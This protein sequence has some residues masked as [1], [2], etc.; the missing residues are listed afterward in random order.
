MFSIWWGLGVVLVISL[1]WL[2]V[3]IL[4]LAVG[5]RM[6]VRHPCRSSASRNCPLH[7]TSTPLLLLLHSFVRFLFRSPTHSCACGHVEWTWRASR[8]DRRLLR[9]TFKHTHTHICKFMRKHSL[10]Y[11]HNDFTCASCR[12]SFRFNW[13]IAHTNTNK[14]TDCLWLRSVLLAVRHVRLRLLRRSTL[15]RR[16]HL[17]LHSSLLGKWVDSSAIRLNCGTRTY[18]SYAYED[19]LRHF[20]FDVT[21]NAMR[22]AIARILHLTTVILYAMCVCVCVYV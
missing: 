21:L 6:P 11:S 4:V 9:A 17:H 10:T 3:A 14:R 5:R 13:R 16:M 2:V 20:N 12:F 22:G 7:A 8:R 15:L 19:E 18:I 1:V